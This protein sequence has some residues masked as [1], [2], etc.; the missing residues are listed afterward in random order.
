MAYTGKVVD[1][2]VNRKAAGSILQAQ[3]LLGLVD[4][5]L[6]S[7]AAAQAGSIKIS[8]NDFPAI[9][10]SW[11]AQYLS[12]VRVIPFM[13]SF[14]KRKNRMIGGMDAMIKAARMMLS[15]TAVWEKL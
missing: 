14:W 9:I 3:A 12:P 8:G 2:E 13:I 11:L 6:T 1:I 7:L 4:G 10:Y 5:S 15:L